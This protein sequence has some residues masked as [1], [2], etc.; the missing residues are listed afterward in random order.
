MEEEKAKKEEEGPS[1]NE[2]REEVALMEPHLVLRKDLEEVTEKEEEEETTPLPQSPSP[3]PDVDPDLARDLGAPPPF[4]SSAAVIRPFTEKQLAALFVND[5]LEGAE[6][7][8]R[9]FLLRHRQDGREETRLDE[10]L[11]SYHRCRE[12]LREVDARADRHL[13]HSESLRQNLWRLDEEAVSDVGECQD[14]REV[15][16]RHVYTTARFDDRASGELRGHLSDLRRLLLDSH[17]LDAFRCEMWRLRIED[18]LH[19]VLREAE[20]D[21]QAADRSLGALFDFCRRPGRNAAVI[22]DVRGWLDR[23]VAAM[24]RREDGED[25]E[26]HLLILQQVLRCPSGVGKWA[27][28]FV[29]V[30]PPEI[31]VLVDGQ[32]EPCGLPENQRIKHMMAV[33]SVLMSPIED[34]EEF[35][36]PMRGSLVSPT[37]EREEDPDS[38]WSVVDQEGEED[39][40]LHD[41]WHLLGDADLVAIFDQIPFDALFR[42]LLNVDRRDGEFTYDPSG[43][44]HQSFM[45]IFAVASRLVRELRK[46][47]ETFNRPR[48]RSFAKR[49]CHV[50]RETLEFV[51]RHWQAFKELRKEDGDNN[52]DAMMKRIQVEYDAFFMRVVRSIFSAHELGTWQ[53]FT[54]IPY[55]AVTMDTLW[56]VFYVLHLDYHEDGCQNFGEEIT[57]RTLKETVFFVF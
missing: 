32:E 29:Q 35:L 43:C 47:F 20:Q 10:L 5:H 37:P 50:I 9:S 18:H 17:S 8:L 2:L 24:V 39:E 23:L 19:A 57:G 41:T 36:K 30:P 38:V 34:R 25:F 54:Y 31:Q 46:G 1:F 45:Q 7:H 26:A 13:L 55:G 44:T 11:R 33:I 22:E 16:A 48:F 14:G 4:S 49:I 42:F 15:K 3:P 51:T 28:K 6:K 12:S 40:D 56:K 27:A 21:R 53:Y 52:D